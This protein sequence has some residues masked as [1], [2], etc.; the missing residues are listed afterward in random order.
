VD[1][2]YGSVNSD[3]NGKFSNSH[4]LVM[5]YVMDRTHPALAHQVDVVEGLAKYFTTVTVLTGKNGYRPNL[6][7][8]SVISS[9]WDPGKNVRNI[10]RF[11]FHFFSIIYRREYSSVFSHMTLVQSALVAPMLRILNIRHFVWYAHAR[12][13]VYLSWTYFWAS[14]IITSTRG[15]CPL[16]GKKVIYLGQSVDPIQFPRREGLR[17][18]MSSC[19]HVGRMD[20]SKNLEMIISTVQAL[21]VKFP[22][23]TLNLV[24]SP[25][26]PASVEYVNSLKLSWASALEQGWLTFEDAIPRV[27]VPEKLIG[28]D[29]FIHAFPGSLDKSLIEAT[30]TA[31]P[32]VTTNQEYLNEFG[33]WGHGEKSLDLELA[34]LLE[35]SEDDLKREIEA[36][37][38]LGANNHSFSKWVSRLASILG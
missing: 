19:V 27:R 37:V 24:G 12:K 3:E 4:L 7:N 26:T 15:S 18:P 23:L 20:P 31:M 16:R 1:S 28:K 38:A 35:Y 17:F 29:I 32:V 33:S 9:N 8:I 6:Q 14:A 34:A 2:S 36:R 22:F 21:K 11:Y 25:S 30:L 10:L 13:N 5:N